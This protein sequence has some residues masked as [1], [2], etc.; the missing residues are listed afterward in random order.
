MNDKELQEL[1]EYVIF[2]TGALAVGVCLVLPDGVLRCANMVLHESESPDPRMFRA[3]A[4]GLENCA[5]KAHGSAAQ[6][7]HVFS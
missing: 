7:D 4:E 3:L 5:Q 6:Y 2:H 1:L